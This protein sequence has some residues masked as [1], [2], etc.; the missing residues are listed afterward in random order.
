[1]IQTVPYAGRLPKFD[2]SGVDDLAVARTGRHRLGA[3]IASRLPGL[4]FSGVDNLAVVLTGSHRLKIMKD[5]PKID[6]S[7]DDD[8]SIA[9]T[10]DS[11]N[12]HCQ[13]FAKTDFK[14][15]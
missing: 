15:Q 7:R 12:A 5:F 3:P 6:P 4:D 14:S 9:V 8:L 13:P 11:S 10:T 1:M 2:F